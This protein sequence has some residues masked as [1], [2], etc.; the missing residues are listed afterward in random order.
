MRIRGVLPVAVF[1]VLA[2]AGTSV[3][4]N[5]SGARL[6][7]AASAD[8]NCPRHRVHLFGRGKNMGVEA[9]GQH[10]TYRNEDGEWVLVNRDGV[11][12]APSPSP[13][14]SVTVLRPVSPPPQSITS[15]TGTPT[16][17]PPSTL[18]PSSPPGSGQKSL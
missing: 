13:S 4:C 9:C 12:A 14:P 8:L 17:P 5:R 16:M 2:L 7:E 10:A 11:A 1:G 6:R 15:P 18:P 3:G